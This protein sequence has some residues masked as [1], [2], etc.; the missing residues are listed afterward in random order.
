MIKVYD[1]VQWHLDGGEEKKEVLK[2]FA[3]IFKFLLDNKML[4][5]EGLEIV[6]D[7]IDSS[8]SLNEQVVNAEGKKFLDKYYD[9]VLDCNS[10]E[11]VKCLK[12]YI[13]K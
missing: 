12:S 11:V 2:K 13:N 9:N 7:G 1:K 6:D 10:S 3:N 8:I 4:N 5:N